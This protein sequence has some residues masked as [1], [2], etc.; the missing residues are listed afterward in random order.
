MGYGWGLSLYWEKQH[1]DDL[2]SAILSAAIVWAVPRLDI[3][4]LF[5]VNLEMLRFS[6]WFMHAHPLPERPHAVVQ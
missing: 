5:C 3:S 2:F 1:E 4:D 6:S